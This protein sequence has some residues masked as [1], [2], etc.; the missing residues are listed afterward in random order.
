M[1]YKQKDRRTNKQKDKYDH[2]IRDKPLNSFNFQE[3]VEYVHMKGLGDKV[4]LLLS[5]LSGP[6]KTD[7]T[8]I[9]LTIVSDYHICEHNNHCHD[10]EQGHVELAISKPKGAGCETPTSEPGYSITDQVL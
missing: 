9:I 10:G 3:R 5:V 1:T 2:D 4:W 6:H 8:I 7:A